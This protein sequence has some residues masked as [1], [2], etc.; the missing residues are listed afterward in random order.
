MD[1]PSRTLFALFLAALWC[2]F[3]LYG[4]ARLAAR[5]PQGRELLAR[6]RRR[7]PLAQ[8]VALV[9]SVIVVA[10]GGSKP[11]GGGNGGGGG[12]LGSLARPP[13]P[14]PEP[15][16]GLVEV[17]TAGV[18]LR[19][20]PTNAVEAAAWR[21]RGASEDGFW[22]ERDAPFFALGTNPVR[23]VYAS[24]SGAL[25]FESARHPPLGAPLPDSAARSESSPH[26]ETALLA[27]P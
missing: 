22:I 5:S 7:G 8:G 9:L 1:D 12:L 20:E 15:A 19:A 18:S 3:A 16:F 11:G 23:R 26:L 27:P 13:E 17:R 21:L 24:A 6:L 2:G 10:F 25:S 14:P 4:L